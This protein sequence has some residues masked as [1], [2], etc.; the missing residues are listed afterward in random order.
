MHAVDAS[1]KRAS[2]SARANERM[3]ESN[4]NRGA[5]STRAERTPKAPHR[6]GTRR[7]IGSTPYVSDEPQRA[8]P[9]ERTKAHLRLLL[10]AAAT[11]TALTA[12]GFMAVDPMPPPSK[13]QGT[14]GFFSATAAWKVS[15]GTRLLEITLKA[16]PGHADVRITGQ[17][18]STNATVMD[19]H[20][21]GDT[22]TIL[23]D[24]NPAY[25]TLLTALGISCAAGPASL[26]IQVRQEADAGDGALSVTLYDVATF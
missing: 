14:A 8:G 7:E 21:D 17:A 2:M 4:R 5:W 18:T 9:R 11:G 23:V 13:C 26:N 6:I 16:A 15:G 19:T 20:T 1:E 10:A 24:P 3:S 22:T 25:P 12:C